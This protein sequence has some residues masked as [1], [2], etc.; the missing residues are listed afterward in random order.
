MLD[1]R[2]AFVRCALF[3]L[4]LHTVVVAH[5]HTSTL[6]LG[7]Q[8][9]DALWDEDLHQRLEPRQLVQLSVHGE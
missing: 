1:L 5:E 8:R 9:H 3:G 4:E 6:E 7:R 2:L